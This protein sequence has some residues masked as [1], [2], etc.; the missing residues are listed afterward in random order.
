MED[1]QNGYGKSHS[2]MDWM[3]TFGGTLPMTQENVRSPQ[4]SFQPRVP[5]PA[6]MSQVAALQGD[7][8]TPRCLG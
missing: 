4:A 2:K 1:Y 8:S 3:M 7:P 5:G 6:Q